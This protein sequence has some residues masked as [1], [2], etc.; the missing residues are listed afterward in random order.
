MPSGAPPV[1][2]Q[3]SEGGG[4]FLPVSVAGTFLPRWVSG[5][6]N[7]V[8]FNSGQP[9]VGEDT[10]GW[11]DV[12][13]WEREGS[14]SCGVVVPARQDGG[15]VSLLSGGQSSNASYFIDASGDGGDAY[16]AS[17][18]PLVARDR[19]EKMEMYDARVSGGFPEE[20]LACTGTGCQGV[21][22]TPPVFET[23]A[24]VTFMGSGNVAP[25]PP[26]KKL[27]R[28][29]LLARALKACHAKHG[30]AR[31]ACEVAARKRYG[32]RK[33]GSAR[34]A[35]AGSVTAAGAGAGFGFVGAIGRGR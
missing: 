35:G 14:G 4:S 27:S 21:P 8:F 24:S 30:R 23:P 25:P 34:K 7:R 1:Q 15:C 31:A 11:Q 3:A 28:A 20:L 12:Y 26:P 33:R 13:E 2:E 9:L 5:D 19:A 16:F 6:G 32:S 18:Q 17:R 29:Q 10:N 22:P